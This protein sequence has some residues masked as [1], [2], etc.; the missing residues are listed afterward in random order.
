MIGEDLIKF[1]GS[2]VMRNIAIGRFSY[3]ESTK[4]LVGGIRSEDK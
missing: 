1:T 2:R 4:S 3:K